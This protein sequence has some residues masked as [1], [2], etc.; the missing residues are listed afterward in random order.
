LQVIAF[1]ESFAKLRV[2]VGRQ[3]DCPIRL[4]VTVR[5]IALGV[6]REDNPAHER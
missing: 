2:S 1:K 3:E 4:K 5:N 6:N